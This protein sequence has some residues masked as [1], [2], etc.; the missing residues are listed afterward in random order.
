[1]DG[2]KTAMLVAICVLGV[3]LGGCTPMATYPPIEGSFELSGPSTEPIPAL[4]VASIRYVHDKFGGEGGD[5]AI[6][7]PAGTPAKVYD[8]VIKRLD[9]GRPMQDPAEPAY[10]V[11]AVRVRGWSAEVDIFHPRRDGFYEFVTLSMQRDILPM[12][13]V[14]NTRMWRTGDVP[15]G[16]NYV[17]AN[18]ELAAAEPTESAGD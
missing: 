13:K 7:L 14:T 15:P 6:N 12:Y 9:A 10:H 1:M 8:L 2:T 5:Y 18:A 11:T 17:A 3:Y 16:P 4:M